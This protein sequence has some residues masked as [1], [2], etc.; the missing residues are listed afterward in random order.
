[1]CDPEPPPRR[2]AS[3]DEE[4]AGLADGR[5]R[6]VARQRT[7]AQ[8]PRSRWLPCVNALRGGARVYC[9]PF[10]G[11]SAASLRPWMRYAAERGVEIHPIELP[12]HGT[13]VR[14]VAHTN[15]GE[16]VTHIVDEVF[17]SVRSPFALFGHS[18]G[19]LIAQAISLELQRRRAMLPTR[20]FVSAATPPG[21]GTERLLHTLD[22]AALLDELVALGGMAPAVLAHHELLQL[23]IPAIRADLQVTE[24]WAPCSTRLVLPITAFSASH[25]ASASPAHMMAWRV[26]TTGTFSQRTFTGGHFYI[27]DEWPALVDCI[28]EAV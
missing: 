1:M 25:D 2:P 17:A 14:E 28:A 22:S 27:N 26:W 21:T 6:T 23:V 19:A 3:E 4:P 15:M 24:R 7:P 20:L 9:L 16:L 10:A 11:G 5:S 13:R 18:A 12:G 8:A